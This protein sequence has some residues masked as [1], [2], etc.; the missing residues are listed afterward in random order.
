M[1]ADETWTGVGQTGERVKPYTKEELHKEFA[2]FVEL[3]SQWGRGDS[4]EIAAIR[5]TLAE[6]EREVERLRD[7]VGDL[8]KYETAL[9]EMIEVFEALAK[10]KRTEPQEI[11]SHGYWARE[12]S[13]RAYLHCA[14]LL[15]RA[16][17]EKRD[18]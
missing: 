16:A 9:W 10:R 18:G 17:Q 12:G 14:D 13:C 8:V 4:Q 7:T 5:A 3:A 6:Q 11:N 2:K 15:I 1:G